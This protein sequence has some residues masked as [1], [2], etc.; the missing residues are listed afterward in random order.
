MTQRGVT[1]SVVEQAALACLESVGWQAMNGAWLDFP[2]GS[3]DRDAKRICPATASDCPHGT[4]S[5]DSLRRVG[6]L[7]SSWAG[8]RDPVRGCRS[9]IATGIP[10]PCRDGQVQAPPAPESRHQSRHHVA[11]APDEVARP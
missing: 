2:R 5:P 10:T 7:A 3:N 6:H 11:I 4:A 9:M 1:E 8:A